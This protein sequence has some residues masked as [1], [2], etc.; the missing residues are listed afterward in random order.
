MVPN[1]GDSKPL[2]PI[3]NHQIWITWD[4]GPHFGRP[5]STVTQ[6]TEVTAVLEASK[7]HE[8]FTSRTWKMLEKNWDVYGCFVKNAERLKT[9]TPKI[10]KSAISDISDIS[11]QRAAG[12]YLQHPAAWISARRCCISAACN[13]QTMLLPKWRVQSRSVPRLNLASSGFCNVLS[14]T[15]G[16]K[17]P[18]SRRVFFDAF[19]KIVTV[20]EV[21]KSPPK[22]RKHIDSQT[23]LTVKEASSRML[24]KLV[25]VE[26][27]QKYP[28]IAMERHHGLIHSSPS[29]VK[30]VRN[31]GLRLPLPAGNIF[32]KVRQLQFRN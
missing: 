5:I 2:A 23:I 9:E 18:L 25:V 16:R 7:A 1:I 6:V 31:N 28:R 24:Q 15:L 12:W 4:L 27:Y 26:L 20:Y 13:Q 29:P 19:P 11:T 30:L 14:N 32:S 21:C 10:S 8:L 22:I 17:Q 3:E